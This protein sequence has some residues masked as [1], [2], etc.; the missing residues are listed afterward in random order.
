M[1]I[2]SWVR[3]G[4]W[5]LICGAVLAWGILAWGLGWVSPRAASA[6]AQQQS[7]SAVVAAVSPYCV[8]RFEQQSNAVAAWKKLNT[9]AD[10][11]NQDEFLVKGNWAALPGSRMDADLANAIADKCASS[12]LALKELDGVKLSSSR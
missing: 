11:Y 8:S 3:P 1:Q 10:N 6:M 5:G 9:S 7:E 4:I 2:P 12:L